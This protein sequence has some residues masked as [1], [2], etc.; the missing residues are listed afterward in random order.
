MSENEEGA[1]VETGDSTKFT[2]SQSVHCSGCSKDFA[3]QDDY[4]DHIYDDGR[5][6]RVYLAS[7]RK[8]MGKE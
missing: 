1:G 5:C 2:S 7:D 8:D 4:L 3:D 6:Y